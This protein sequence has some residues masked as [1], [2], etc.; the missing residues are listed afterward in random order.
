[1]SSSELSSP[2]SSLPSD[3]GE[4]PEL[5]LDK[6][7]GSAV[8]ASDDEPATPVSTASSTIKRKREESPPH[9][10]VL[11]DN[12]DIAVSLWRVHRVTNALSFGSRILAEIT[13]LTYFAIPQFI[14]MFRSRFSEVFP[15]KL[16]NLG[17][18]DIERG[19]VDSV[20]SPQVEGLLCA[21]LALVL[22]RKKPIESVI[23]FCT[24]QLR[25]WKF[26]RL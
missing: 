21:L 4:I 10:E 6:P 11:A 18:Q 25:T 16:V 20:P 17:P 23:P 26:L 7:D 13:L 12:P 1:M 9:E 15:P 24:Y 5:L 22:N 2:L 14:V 19:V 3:D 8:I